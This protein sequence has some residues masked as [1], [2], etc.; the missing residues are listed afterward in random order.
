LVRKN[1]AL[2][3]GMRE[4]LRVALESC[5][6][7]LPQPGA[8]FPEEVPFQGFIGNL[9]ALLPFASPEVGE[10]YPIPLK[11][12]GEWKTVLYTVDR[13]ID[14]S[15]K[16]FGTPMNA[17]GF[18][19]K[20]APPLLSFIGSTFP[21]G[22][23]YAATHGKKQVNEWL[24]DKKDVRLYGASLGGAMTFQTLRHD[25][26]GRIAQ[27][28]AFNPPGLYS[29]DWKRPV[30]AEVNIY[31][32]EGDIVSTMGVFPE[33]AKVNVLHLIPDTPQKGFKA[34]ALVHTGRESHTILKGDAHLE[35][36]RFVRK[37]LTGLHITLGSLLI[38]LPMACVYLLY[39]LLHR[40]P[41][42][43]LKVKL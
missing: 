5:S 22:D 37:L 1:P 40:L 14:M 18:T 8:D 32:Q 39:T 12:N 43:A 33:G 2:L 34:H 20:D 10:S 15:P 41:S 28:N 42:T 36:S 30:D 17:Y 35:N 13:K 3:K 9:I 11:I 7:M 21:A 29:W 26:E 4:E 16:W 23:G 27:V 25:K 19:A 24:Q 6:A 31:C 38:F